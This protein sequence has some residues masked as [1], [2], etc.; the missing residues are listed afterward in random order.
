MARVVSR[1]SSQSEAEKQL[2]LGETAVELLKQVADLGG[3]PSNAEVE[4]LKN[5]SDSEALRDRPDW[6]SLIDSLPKEE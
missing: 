5:D 3:F 6:K 4:Q 1:A 2:E